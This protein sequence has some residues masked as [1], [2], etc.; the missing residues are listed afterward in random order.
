MDNAMPDN[1]SNID[2]GDSQ[3]QGGGDEIKK[4]SGLTDIK[5]IQTFLAKG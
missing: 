2:G 1:I 5:Q 3:D 4:G